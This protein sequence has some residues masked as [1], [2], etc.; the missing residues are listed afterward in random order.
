MQNNYFFLE[1]SLSVIKM[2][3]LITVNIKP[4]QEDFTTLGY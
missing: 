4:Y 2:K 3:D 1:K